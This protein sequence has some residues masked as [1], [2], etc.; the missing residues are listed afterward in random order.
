MYDHVGMIAPLILYKIM[1]LLNKFFLKKLTVSK[2]IV[3]SI[4]HLIRSIIWHNEQMNLNF[5]FGKYPLLVT[6]HGLKEL[7]KLLL[8]NVTD[9]FARN[10]HDTVLHRT[11]HN[12]DKEVIELIVNKIKEKEDDIEP[13]I[14]F[15]RH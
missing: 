7:V 4:H 9:V 13:H 14:N 6:Q 5:P 2:M 1:Q 15:T 10:N 12:N 11:V 8:T 3:T